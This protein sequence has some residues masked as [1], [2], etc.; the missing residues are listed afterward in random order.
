MAERLSDV[1]LKVFDA[2]GHAPHLEAPNAFNTMLSRFL[3]SH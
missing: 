3:G 2:S 1:E